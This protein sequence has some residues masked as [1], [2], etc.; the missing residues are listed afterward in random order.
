MDAAVLSLI[1]MVKRGWAQR[2]NTEFAVPNTTTARGTCPMQCARHS[3]KLAVETAV[4][5][6]KLQRVHVRFSDK[7]RNSRLMAVTATVPAQPS[8]TAVIR[9]N[10]QRRMSAANTHSSFTNT[11]CEHTITCRANDCSRDDVQHDHPPRE[12]TV[13]R[14]RKK[15]RKMTP[16]FPGQADTSAQQAL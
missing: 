2:R 13:N 16:R 6:S 8:S 1:D 11:P 10:S 5:C 3:G 14:H 9:Q 12:H 7:R 15:T 4:Q